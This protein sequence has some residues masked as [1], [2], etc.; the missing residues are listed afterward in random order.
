M[1]VGGPGM[2]Y[3]PLKAEICSEWGGDPTGLEGPGLAPAP[4]PALSSAL[5]S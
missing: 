1:Y 2:P 3:S 4:T 5:L